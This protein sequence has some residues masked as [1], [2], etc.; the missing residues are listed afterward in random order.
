MIQRHRHI[1]AQ[2]LETPLSVGPAIVNANH[3]QKVQY[4]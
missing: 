2:K 1:F 3:F 4:V